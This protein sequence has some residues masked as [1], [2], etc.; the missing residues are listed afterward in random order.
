VLNGLAQ[1]V[2]LS[3]LSTRNGGGGSAD[4]TAPVLSGVSYDSGTNTL[5]FTSDEAGT[6]YWLKNTSATPLPGAE[7]A[8]A[9]DGFGAATATANSITVNDDAW[10]EAL[11]R[12]HL[13]V[14][15]A[16]GNYSTDTVT[17]AYIQPDYVVDFVSGGTDYLEQTSA[18]FDVGGG[19]LPADGGWFSFD[20][21]YDG[22]NLNGIAM[23]V[24]DTASA[25]SYIELSPTTMNSRS[26]ATNRITTA[27]AAPS[28]GWHRITGRFTRHASTVT[29]T[30]GLYYYRD[31]EAVVSYTAGSTTGI[32]PASYNKIRL[33]QRSESGSGSPA[34][35]RASSFAM[36]YGDPAAMHA[37]LYNGGAFGRQI[38][39]YNFAG[40]GGC[41]LEHYWRGARIGAATLSGSETALQDTVG[42][43]D[44]WTKTGSPVWANL[45]PP[46]TSGVAATT[47]SVVV[48]NV[49]PADDLVITATL[50][51]GKVWN[52]PTV[53][54]SKLDIWTTRGMGPVN[55]SSYSVSVA[56]STATITCQLDRVIYASETGASYEFA[57]NWVLDSSGNYGQA[58]TGT[59]TNSSAASDP[60]NWPGLSSGRAGVRFTTATPAGFY[61]DG[62]RS[63]VTTGA[64]IASEYP[65]RTTWGG[66][67]VHGAMYN[68][69]RRSAK[70]P[71]D[72]RVNNAPQYEAPVSLPLTLATNDSYIKSRCN[73]YPNSSGGGTSLHPVRV[74]NYMEIHCRASAPA[75]NEMCP[76]IVYDTPASRP[77]GPTID[78]SALSLPSY[79][80]VGHDRPTIADV[81]ARM[82]RSNPAAAL[83][84]AV[85]T[86]RSFTPSGFTLHDGYGSE[87]I[88]T[89]NAAGLAMIGDDAI[90]LRRTLAGLL[91]G[92][93]V[94][95][96]HAIKVSAETTLP[97]DGG[98]NQGFLLP[99][100][101]YLG[102]TGQTSAMATLRADVGTNELRC[103]ARFDSTLLA[104]CTTVASDTPTYHS[105]GSYEWF[106]KGPE[107]YANPESLYNPHAA[108]GYRNLNTWA[109]ELVALQA[110]GYVH[111]AWDAFRGYVVRANLP[112]EPSF[113]NYPS[114]FTGYTTSSNP[115][116]Y[117]WDSGF[118]TSHWT[119]ISAVTQTVG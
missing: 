5:L 31:A 23:S 12:V 79:S 24:G 62:I 91:I 117:Q 92:H 36:G 19:T 108:A 70:Q 107:N 81:T 28:V 87:V 20:M 75:A 51:G 84:S 49:I 42:S 29:T 113:D 59:V 40:D 8:A 100:A 89:T 10:G 60:T 39:D 47:S 65:A 44:A 61:P 18:V 30:I 32:A 46:W 83:L 96:Y 27:A 6:Y 99:V 33:G 103:P 67:A 63:W 112:N 71:F 3:G 68:P 104:N 57:Q 34:T 58:G 9:A 52:T 35:F 16:A 109:G 15:D 98:Q 64:Q 11:W 119:T 13:T 105:V 74:L 82:A 54:I 56:G 14:K 118:W 26:S 86:R 110:L 1:L 97:A 88:E 78:V 90:A 85:E 17:S 115:G 94:Q 76:A 43:L 4:T 101:L 66:F 72:E 102:V 50:P 48:A 41:T 111:S 37:W 80:T 114:H 38:T 73:P 106:K 21:Y 77:A 95:I 22:T 53:D 116:G 2:R 55:V 45:A 93:G 25:T 69:Y 7:I